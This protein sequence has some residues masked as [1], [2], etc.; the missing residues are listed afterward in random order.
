MVKSLSSLAMAVILA[1]CTAAPGDVEAAGEGAAASG[2]L[3][4]AN[5]RDGSLSFIDLADGEE[6]ARVRTCANPHE[7]SLSPDRAHLALACYGGSTLEIFDT[8]TME[9]IQRIE[10]GEGARPHGVVWHDSGM[11]VASAEGRGSIFTVTDAPGDAPQ[12][13]EIHSEGEGPHMVAVSAAGDIA[14]GTV[15]PTGTVIR[16][17]LAAGAETSR[18]R[19]GGDTEGIALSPDGEVLF[20]GAN[21]ANLVYRL[22]P[23]TLDI[24]G[25][26]ETGTVPIRVAPHPAL[27]IVV[28][29]DFGDG[30]VTVVDAESGAALRRIP[31][32]GRQS[33][34]QVTLVFS[35]DGERIYVAETANDAIAEVD[36]ASGEVLRRLA[37]GPGGDGLAVVD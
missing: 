27:P 1:S 32:S 30:A 3:F 6:K 33:A 26:T 13:R 24:I 8:A 18:R 17:D 36:F 2:T 9:R 31:V 15:I 19:L 4:V 20:V 37:T 28:S 23:D 7:L 25:Q 11:I 34:V 29:S 21:S 35:E 5:K 10:L 14:W 12:V 16:Y 22:D